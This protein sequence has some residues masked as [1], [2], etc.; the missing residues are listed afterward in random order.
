MD[1]NKNHYDQNKVEAKWVKI[2]DESKIY[3]VKKDPTKTKYY[4]LDTFVSSAWYQF[5]FTDS[6][7]IKNFASKEK[8]D[9]WQNVDHYSGTIEH[10]TAHLIYARF[11]TKVLFDLDFVPFD[12]PFPKYTPVGLLV[13][14][15]G[16]RF[17]KRL[18]NAPETNDLIEKYGGDLLRLS[19]QFISPYED[20]S[21]WGEQDIVAVKRFRDRVWR[22]FT[23]RVKDRTFDV[24]L[25][26]GECKEELRILVDQVEK[27]IIEMKYNVVLS[28]LMVFINNRYKEE[29]NISK[30]VWEIFTKLLA[31]LAPFIAEEMWSQMGHEASIHMEEWPKL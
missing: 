26:I 7:N 28:K 22:L 30:E 1:P 4:A 31:P 12:E 18:G 15:G 10:L 27:N 3:D 2:W 29:K 23:Q 8:L 5:R 11:I 9:Y 21:K 14:K 25:T 19:C 24:T 16:T 6:N 13:D 20:I 17:S